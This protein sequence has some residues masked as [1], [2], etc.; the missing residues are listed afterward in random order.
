[1]AIATRPRVEDPIVEQ[2]VKE[3]AAHRSLYTD[4]AI[5]ALE[6][7]RIFWRTWVYV[8]HESEVPNPGDYK[9]TDIA[10]RR[11]IISRHSDGHVHVLF[12]SCMHRG[13]VVCEHPSGH[14][15]HF[16]CPYHSWTYRTNGELALIPS[17]QAFGPDFDL[18]DYGLR[19]VPRAASYRGFLFVSLNPDVPDLDEH[20]GRAKHYIDIFVDRS[21]AGAIEVTKPLKYE[22]HGN[23]KLQM[24]NM[25]DG[26]HAQFVHASIGCSSRCAGRTST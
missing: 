17:Q 3:D 25:S 14:T 20:L 24:E 23:W 21:P 13:T 6:M 1:M 9:T 5:Y 12:N 11:I 8:A 19:H 10:G 15:S 26:Y 18:S 7:Q 22:Y 4:P 16:R 2:L